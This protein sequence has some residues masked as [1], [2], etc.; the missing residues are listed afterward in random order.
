[1]LFN[2]IALKELVSKLELKDTESVP[3]EETTY[4]RHRLG[5]VRLMC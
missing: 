5:G 2:E 1:M 3:E 4:E